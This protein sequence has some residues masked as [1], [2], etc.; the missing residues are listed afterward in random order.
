[1]W[2]HARLVE[3]VLL[4]HLIMPDG[5]FGTI[6]VCNFADVCSFGAV[7]IRRAGAVAWLVRVPEVARGLRLVMVGVVQLTVGKVS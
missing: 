2:R 1:M 5:G 3:L 7:W 6:F 4:R